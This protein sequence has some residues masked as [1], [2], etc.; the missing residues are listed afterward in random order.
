MTNMPEN[1]KLEI[2]DLAKVAEE[3]KS[4]IGLAIELEREKYLDLAKQESEGIINCARE[5]AETIIAEGKEKAQQIV[6]EIELHAKEEATKIT[7]EAKNS[8][9]QILSEADDRANKEAESIMLEAKRHAQ[10]IIKEAE[11]RARKEAKDRKKRELE[12]L[13]D[14]AR[15]EAEKQSAR[16]INDSRIQAEQTINEAK[17]TAQ[18]EASSESLNIITDARQTAKKVKERSIASVNE[19]YELMIELVQDAEN[20]IEKLRAEMPTRLEGLVSTIVKVK[21]N[22][23]NG[24]AADELCSTWATK[25]YSTETEEQWF[26]GQKQI[27]IALPYDT[28]Q[29]N[30]LVEYLKHIPN[31]KIVG[32]SGNR[33]N[34]II[35]LDVGE[36]IPLLTIL[37]GI[38]SVV[39][40]DVNG[41]VIELKLDQSKMAMNMVSASP[42]SNS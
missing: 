3:Y 4:K 6:D 11:D 29:M 18:A 37:K 10:E 42:L 15:K 33:D 38:P 8:A 17:K 23:Q 7:L 21:E 14:E 34:S 13:I 5:K 24:N 31:T 22:L 27:K 19:T 28:A 9:E 30:K 40:A 16:I 39:S 1:V 41:D 32:Q 26:N 20:A 12:K 2:D 35:Y 36:P 25:H